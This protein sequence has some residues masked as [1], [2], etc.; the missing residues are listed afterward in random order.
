MLDNNIRLAG[1]LDLKSKYIYGYNKKKVYKIFY[2]LN[3]NYSKFIIPYKDTLFIYNI[4]IIAKI[5]KIDNDIIIGEIIEKI[6]N[7][8][9]PNIEIYSKSLL[10]YYNINIIKNNKPFNDINLLQIKYYNNIPE[11]EKNINF[12]CN[13]D[14]LY[15]DDIDDLISYNEINNQ[16]IIGIHICDIISVL[17]ILEIDYNDIARTII[18]SNMYNTIYGYNKKYNILND[19]LIKNFLSL[20]LNQPRYV[21]SI[22]IYYDN[23]YNI[24]NYVNNSEIL[25]NKNTYTYEEANKLLENNSNLYLKEISNFCF[26][27]GKQYPEIYN[28]Y[29]NHIYNSHYI[30]AILMII[31]NQYMGNL[32]K[33]E[34]ETIFRISDNF[35]SEY[36][37]NDNNNYHQILNIHNYLHFTSPIRR[38]VDQYNHLIYYKK[39]KSSLSFNYKIDIDKMNN[40]IKNLKYL[41]NKFKL[42]KLVNKNLIL[43]LLDF[44][45]NDNNLYLKWLIDNNIF[46][47]I[48]YDAYI[49]NINDNINFINRLNISESILLIK[50]NNYKL[51]ISLELT[52]SYNLPK[53]LINY[54]TS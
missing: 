2:P 29:D 42:L 49:L 48:I 16:K 24:I 37:Y 46:I 43:K 1:V 30:I 45:F 12:I 51:K 41:N 8:D 31:Y 22:Y 17:K 40:E 10:Y 27:I 13:I 53:I 25:I 34:N 14:P 3:N 6:G 38:F 39:F 28:S 9:K 4:I 33:L 36:K 15:C 18:D 32:L 7:L 23:N 44:K 5:K 20:E 21:L 50:N 47:D 54:F 52:G 35:E 26:H 19:Y 11:K